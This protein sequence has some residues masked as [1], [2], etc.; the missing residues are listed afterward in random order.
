MSCRRF[1]LDSFE[2]LLGVSTLL[3]N[4]TK[5]LTVSKLFRKL[6]VR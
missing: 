6:Q 3:G 4:A 2:A 1:T 5:T